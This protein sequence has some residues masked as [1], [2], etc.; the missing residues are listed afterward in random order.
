MPALEMEVIIIIN[1]NLLFSKK[2][3]VYSNQKT[4]DDYACV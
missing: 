2:K 3:K 4:S 1:V